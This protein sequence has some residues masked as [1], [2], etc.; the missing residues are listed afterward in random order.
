AKDLGSPAFVI[1]T[2]L[3]IFFVSQL[4]VAPILVSLGHALFSP[5]KT[6]DFDNS[7]PLQFFF[8]LI[9]EAAV[10][11]MAVKLVRRRGLSL[12]V[13]GLG[14]RPALRDLWL[15]VLGAGGFYLL[16]I[17]AGIII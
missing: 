8:I 12:K 4:L 10:A 7:I 6:L 15:A 16:L 2:A 1:V 9:A 3:L 5:H 14:R 17:I 11:W 13:I